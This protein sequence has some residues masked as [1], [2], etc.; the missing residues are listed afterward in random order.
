MTAQPDFT[1]RVYAAKRHIQ[2]YI[3]LIEQSDRHQRR[4]GDPFSERLGVFLN[5][6]IDCAPTPEGKE[7]V[8]QSVIDAHSWPE[9]VELYDHYEDFL[10]FPSE[11]NR[12]LTRACPYRDLFNSEDCR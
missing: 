10:I 3:P 7:R 5:A 12:Y 4:E 8:A 11:S 2:H 6:M 1:D 9:L